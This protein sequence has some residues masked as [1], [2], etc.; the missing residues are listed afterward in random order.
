MP[1]LSY[2]SGT[3]Q[4]ALNMVLPTKEP[5]LRPVSAARQHIVDSVER[6]LFS[7]N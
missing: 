6:Q 1:G 3:A 4:L 5:A 7:G 2:V